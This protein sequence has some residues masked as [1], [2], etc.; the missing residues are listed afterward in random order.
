MNYWYKLTC[1]SESNGPKVAASWRMALAT[2]V[3]KKSSNQ[4]EIV[5]A[6]LNIM[7]PLEQVTNSFKI[8]PNQLLKWP[9]TP[10]AVSELRENCSSLVSL[11]GS[12]TY[13]SL[14]SSAT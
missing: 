5:K 11:G 1:G 3:L 4:G 8:T 7:N 9:A 14:V 10:N 13:F 2:A 6:V 12:E